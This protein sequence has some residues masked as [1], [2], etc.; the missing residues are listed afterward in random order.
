[1]TD[2]RA[3]VRRLSDALVDAQK[4]IRI[5]DA[6]KWDHQ[7]ELDFFAAKA[8]ELPKVDASSYARVPLG[9]D[10]PRKASELRELAALI[11]SELG[12]QD[13]LGKLMAEIAAEYALACEML[14]ARGTSRF[15][16]ISRTL[17]GSPKDRFAADSHSI[18]DQSRLLYDTLSVL[19]GKQLGKEYPKSIASGDAVR[20][21][22]RRF[23]SSFMKGQVEVRVSDGIVADAAAGSSE[24]KLKEG[25]LFSLKDI[26]ILEVHEG[27]VHVATT[28]NGR[29]QTTSTFLAKG[30]PR[31]AATQE[32]LAI[33][34]EILTFSSYPLRARSINDRVLGIDKAEDGG[35]FLDLY[36]YYLD[37]GYSEPE[38]FRNSMRVCRGGMVKGGAPF[39]K[40]ISY[41]KGFVENYNFI[42]AAIRRG[43][44][45][46]I[47]FLFAGKM[48]VE[49][50][51][52]L[53]AKHLEGL[54]D[55]PSL[56]PPQFSDL[57]GLA[58]WMSFSN[59][60]NSVDMT[61]VQARYDALFAEHL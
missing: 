50:V 49:D 21:L 26:E 34:M 31:C 25:A 14:A 44:P 51:P 28:L 32:G 43:R 22:Q 4:P 48:R 13:D 36:R 33:L 38:A 40:D 5:L 58:V 54:V 6:I 29:A 56:L 3:K 46:L 17:Y 30:P 24:I 1:M 27:W 45:E 35:D 57:N 41:C 60:L 42:R 15:Y 23:D 61:L 47:P 7:V 12:A 10:P 16:E 19:E 9:F 2:Y 39:T 59:F 52:L 8:R 53:Y 20:A 55:A 37:E 11:G 18:R